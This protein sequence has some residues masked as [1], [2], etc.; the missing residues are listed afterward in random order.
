MNPLLRSALILLV[1]A[2]PM[3]AQTGPGF[4]R[5]QRIAQALNLSEA[6]KTSIRAIREKHRPGLVSRRDAARQAHLALRTALQDANASDATLR[7]LHDKASAA[8]FEVLLAQRSVHHEVEAVL[9]PEQR[10]KAA[11]L[12]GAAQERIRA[13]MRRFHGAGMAG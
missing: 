6:Q 2:L 12:R 4:P 1:T 5:A 3:A 8:R 7:A 9:T 11:E 10:L 13:R